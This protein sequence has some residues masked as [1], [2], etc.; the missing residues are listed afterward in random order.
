MLFKN[1]TAFIDGTFRCMDVRIHGDKI[2]EIAEKLQSKEGEEAID[3]S[4][5]WLLPGFFDVHTHG[6]AGADFSDA[7]TDELYPNPAFLCRVWRD[8]ASCHDNDDGRR[9]QQT[10]DVPDSGCN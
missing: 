10:D 6:R 7:P 1:G 3:I 4:G 9:I 5:K 2:T 8:V